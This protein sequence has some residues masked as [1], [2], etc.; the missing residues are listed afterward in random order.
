MSLTTSSPDR[1]SRQAREHDPDQSAE[2]GADPVDLLGTD[3]REERIDVCAVLG[4][5]IFGGIPQPPAS[6]T[7]DE[8][9]TY[10][11]SPRCG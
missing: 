5:R 6:P 9:G 11:A 3:S 8:I 1:A 10:Y 7:P 4:E 2:R